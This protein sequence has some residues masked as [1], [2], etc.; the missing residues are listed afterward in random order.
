MWCRC[1][2]TRVDSKSPF[3][4]ALMVA[5]VALF[6]ITGCGP[7]KKGGGKSGGKGGSSARSAADAKTGAHGGADKGSAKDDAAKADA[8]GSGG[9]GKAESAADPAKTDAAPKSGTDANGGTDATK[10]AGET[11]GAGDKAGA[12]GGET[13]PAQAAPTGERTENVVAGGAPAAKPAANAVGK[14]LYVRHCASC[15]GDM[16]DGQGVAAKFLYPKP[17]DFRT[18]HFRLV[19][20]KNNVP[21]WADL[22]AV[23]VRGMP[24]SSMPPWAHLSPEDRRAIAEF[25]M[26]LRGEGIRD[27][28]IKS[29]KENDGLTDAEIAA[30]DIQKEIRGA[31]AT[32]T[33]PGES[34]ELPEI[35]A[36]DDAAVARGKEVYVR[37]GCKSCHG[38]TGKGDGAQAMIDDMNLP[39]APRDFTLGIFKG[40]YDPGAIF[41][42]IA[43]GM[44]GTPM[45]VTTN[46]T[47][48]EMVD[49]AHFIRSLS[50]EEMREAA[51]VRRESITVASVPAVSADANA[52]VWA[53]VPVIPVRWMPLWWRSQASSQ[54]RVQAI[55][56]AEKI[57]IRVGWDDVS[58]NARAVLPDEFEDMLAVEL[59]TGDQEPFL[60]MGAAGAPL[61]MWHWR[62]G[63]KDSGEENYILDE[64]PF[65]T[66]TYRELIPKDQLPDFITARV[67]GN[68]VATRGDNAGRLEAAGPG[69]STFRLA[70]SQAVQTSGAWAD[71]KW[72]VVFVRALKTDDGSPSL[73]AGGRASIAF[74][75][76]DGATRDRASQK[77]IT[78]WND[79]KLE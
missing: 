24:G 62:G 55:H 27:E 4:W 14:D 63:L 46:A 47:P 19:S 13:K 2:V 42:R 79:L 17:R 44:P 35:P 39:T 53:S 29:L 8:A 45:P 30:E 20:T 50:T 41:R 48:T 21:S 43:Y 74:A 51:A 15:H 16:G 49:L 67:A 73:Q 64:Y 54:V 26:S 72:T 3:V 70:A 68:P 71:G 9:A 23:L 66:P 28:L 56:D 12:V 18:G 38:D 37:L 32:G 5:A 10:G 78:I 58:P 69:S 61:D 33:T 77:L 76:W 57:A 31:V 22:D 75:K 25:V 40:Q 34:S 52:E 65:D 59:S 60:G 6:A 1:N 7:A 11:K 36:A